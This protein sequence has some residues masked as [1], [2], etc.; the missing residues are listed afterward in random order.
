MKQPPKFV[1]PTRPSYHY[2]LDK[3]L[4]CLKQA[5]WAWYSCLSDKL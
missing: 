4:Y 3:A 1:D 2:R 5:P